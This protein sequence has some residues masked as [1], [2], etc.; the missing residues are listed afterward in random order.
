MLVLEAALH[1]SELLVRER[2]KHLGEQLLAACSGATRLD[3]RLVKQARTHTAL[4]G[5]LGDGP[6]APDANA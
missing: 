5:R 2:S 3:E 1:L 4:Q 6:H